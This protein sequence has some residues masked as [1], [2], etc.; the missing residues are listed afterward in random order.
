MSKRFIVLASIAAIITP[1][2]A[3]AV[4]TF[5]DLITYLITTINQAVG[6]LIALAVLLFIYGV[7][8]YMLAGGDEEAVKTGRKYI[9]WGIIGLAVIVSVWGLVNLL[10]T[11]LGL[12]VSRPP[13]PVI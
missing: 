12:D 10:T 6:F 3:F 11:S 5:A 8:R 2:Y 9:L 13:D 7:V 1:S 4:S